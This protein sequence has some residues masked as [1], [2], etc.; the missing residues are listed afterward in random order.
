MERAEIQKR[1]NKLAS[2]IV[3][4]VEHIEPEVDYI[5]MKFFK[6]NRVFV[7]E[8]EAEEQTVLTLGTTN[9]ERREYD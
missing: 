4:L 5:E 2:E 9:L 6:D 7:L 8:A 1:I 3:E